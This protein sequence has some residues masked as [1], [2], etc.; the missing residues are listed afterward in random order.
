MAVGSTT[1]SKLSMENDWIPK[2]TL[3]LMPDLSISHVRCLK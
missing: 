1:K 3:K 2:Q